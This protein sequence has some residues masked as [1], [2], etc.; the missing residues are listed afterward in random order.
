MLATRPNVTTVKDL[1]TIKWR[2]WI[3]SETL[4]LPTKSNTKC[5]ECDK[6]SSSVPLETIGAFEGA[7]HYR[8]GIYRLIFECMMGSG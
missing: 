7:N 3:S 5:S 1:L 4:R 2:K 8:C 6:S